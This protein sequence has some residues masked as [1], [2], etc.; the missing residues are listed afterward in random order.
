MSE[1]TCTE[2]RCFYGFQIMIENIHSEMYARLIEAYI[3]DKEEQTHMFR[4][5]ETHA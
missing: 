5:I 1:V 3:P 2:A 4:A